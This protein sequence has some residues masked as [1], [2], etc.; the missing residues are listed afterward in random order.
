MPVGEVIPFPE[1]P[2]EY[3]EGPARCTGCRHEWEAVAEVGVVVF[4]CP[5]CEAK[6]GI[7]LHGVAPSSDLW[8]CECGNDLFFLTLDGCQCFNCGAVAEVD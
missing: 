6:K 5:K 7:F 3:L 4:D 1:K 8:E 2:V